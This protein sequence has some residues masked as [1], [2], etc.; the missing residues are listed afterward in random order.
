MKLSRTEKIERPKTRLRLI[1]K[2]GTRVRG[3]MGSSGKVYKI[4]KEKGHGTG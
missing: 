3:C 2:R 1:M 4:L